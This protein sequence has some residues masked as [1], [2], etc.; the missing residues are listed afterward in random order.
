MIRSNILL[1]Y[2]SIRVVIAFCDP[3]MCIYIDQ[4]VC[5]PHTCR[6]QHQYSYQ[7]C[8]SVVSLW[9]NRNPRGTHVYQPKKRELLWHYQPSRTKSAQQCEYQAGTAVVL[10][11]WYWIKYQ[12]L[13]LSDYPGIFYRSQGIQSYDGYGIGGQYCRWYTPVGRLHSVLPG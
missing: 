12:I 4:N 3:C 13:Q 1:S 9:L 6:Y 10:R 8:T 5:P 11:V 2:S 7:V